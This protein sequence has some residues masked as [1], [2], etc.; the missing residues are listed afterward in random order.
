MAAP[1]SRHAR[2]DLELL[3]GDGAAGRVAAAL[4]G[5]A[6]VARCRLHETHLRP[7]VGATAGYVVTWSARGRE[8]DDYVLATTCPVAEGAVAERVRLGDREV[9]AWRHPADPALPGLVRA[10]DVGVAGRMAAVAEPGLELVTYRPLR[11][12][13]VRVTGRPAGGK[14]SVAGRSTTYL[15][16]VRPEIAAGV[17]ARHA[18]LAS[19]GVPVAPARLLPDGVLALAELPGVRLTDALVG[20]GT[21][22]LPPAA[23]LDVLD[24]LPRSL[25]DLPPRGIAVE[26][27]TVHAVA[28]AAMLPEHAPRLVRLAHDVTALV[29]GT[30]PG[31]VVPVHGDLHDANLLVDGGRVVGVLDVDAAGPGHRVD[32]LARLL[33]HLS[34]LAN[35]DPVAHR[36]APEVV[37]RW[38]RAFA[39]VV[40]AAALA[41]RAA[42]VALSLVAGAPGRGPGGGATARI[43]VVDAWRRCALA[44]LGRS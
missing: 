28:A 18:L 4:A 35:L 40:D 8:W 36:W 16:V 38:A 9:R 5:T 44:R 19:G 42:A 6:A 29:A 30:D 10:C 2:D 15:K 34:V 21:R 13:V 12:A 41:A 24:A 43:D 27:T 20:Q 3:G 33:A 26:D 39:E 32:D 17:L 11:R 37:R 1:C 25:L 7:G 22:A 31:P 14:V 23:V